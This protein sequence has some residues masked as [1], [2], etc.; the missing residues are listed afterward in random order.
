MGKNMMEEY[1]RFSLEAALKFKLVG[2]W[3]AFSTNLLLC[4][5]AGA[6][7]PCH[8][9]EQENLFAQLNGTK[10]V[11]LF[12]PK[13]WSRLYPHPVGHPSDRQARVK[14]PKEPGSAKLET[15]KERRNFPMFESISTVTF[16]ATSGAIADLNADDA[17]AAGTGSSGV[18]SIEE[19]GEYYADLQP[20]EILYIPQYWFHQMEALTDNVSL[21]WW[22]KHNSQQMQRGVHLLDP[23]AA[24]LV[25]VRRNLERLLGDLAGGGQKAHQFFLA[26][27]AGKVPIPS[28]NDDIEEPIVSTTATAVSGENDT[29][30]ST[31]SCG[32]TT[33]KTTTKTL[34]VEYYPISPSSLYKN[35]KTEFEEGSAHSLYR[36]S[37]LP[38]GCLRDDKVQGQSS[39]HDHHCLTDDEESIN[40][41]MPSVLA[42]ATATS[43]HESRGD[44]C[45]EFASLPSDIAA[46]D[47]DILVVPAGWDELAK[48]AVQYASII[49]TPEYVRSFIF[50]LVTGRFSGL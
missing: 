35:K 29:T 34:G 36:S 30:A 20:G 38:E 49:L 14:L 8:Y 32:A 23:A 1:M 22:F 15:E 27:A 18:Y 28:V 50:E 24:N 6:I 25:A 39:S 46:A 12:S 41:P 7:T 3:D 33:T 9:D 43:T 19:L 10:R 44:H 16:S 4:G 17:P 40:K 26:L 47:K 5:P 2:G 31:G 45:M 37:V 13:A 11:R 21:S 42:A 48:Q